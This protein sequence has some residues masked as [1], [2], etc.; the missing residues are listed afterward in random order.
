MNAVLKR[1]IIALVAVVLLLVVAAGSTL[2]YL[3]IQTPSVN[4]TFT[5]AQVS[6]AVVEDGTPYTGST[7]SVSN[8]SDVTIRNTSSVPAYIR[9]AIVVTWKAENGHVYAAKPIINQDYTLSLN[10][11]DWTENGGYYYYKQAVAGNSD[12]TNL[13]NSAAQIGENW[14]GTDNTEYSV[15]IE[16]LTEA[17]QADGMGATSP[18]DAWVKAAQ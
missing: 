14:I 17:I 2:A 11:E 8:K 4:N 16:I 3:V 10:T 12:T 13:I 18:Q 7:R 1:T 5:A 15:S 9:V 6:C